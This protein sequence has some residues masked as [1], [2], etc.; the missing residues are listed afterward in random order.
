MRGSRWARQQM[1]RVTMR[2]MLLSALFVASAAMVAPATAAP[3][4][5]TKAVE[6]GTRVADV[7]TVGYRDNCYWRHGRKVC[8]EARR[9]D[10]YRY[11]YYPYYRRPGI[12]L[13]F[14]F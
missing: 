9:Y 5:A 7:T 11:G 1:E 8:R 14:G 13:N 6:T 10:G 2:K 12:T 4:G 3:L